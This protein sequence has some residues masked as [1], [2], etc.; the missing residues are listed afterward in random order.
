VVVATLAGRIKVD[1]PRGTQNGKLLRLNGQGMPAYNNNKKGD[2]FVKVLVQIP[3]NLTN[4][5]Y[6]MF[7]KLKDMKN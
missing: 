2:L 3:E 7:K 5:E 4:R 1:I 6:E